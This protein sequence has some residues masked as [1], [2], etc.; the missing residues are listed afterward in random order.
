MEQT[1][2][3]LCQHVLD[4]SKDKEDIEQNIVAVQQRLC[5]NQLQ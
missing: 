4:M 1:D 5:K 3:P 2:D